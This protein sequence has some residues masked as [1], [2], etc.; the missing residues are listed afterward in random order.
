M[1]MRL[2]LPHCYDVAYVG[3]APTPASASYRFDTVLPMLPMKVAKACCLSS[4]RSL[5]R[6]G[7]A[8][9]PVEPATKAALAW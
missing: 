6:R 5:L 3:E 9:S 8:A 7:S 1:L 2:D 4:G